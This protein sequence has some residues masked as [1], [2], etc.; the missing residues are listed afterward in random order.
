MKRHIRI[1]LAAPTLALIMQVLQYPAAA[2]EVGRNLELST[3]P[4]IGA[5]TAAC[6]MS[7][8]RWGPSLEGLSGP[9]KPGWV[10]SDGFLSVP[11]NANQSLWLLGDTL[12]G[13][14]SGTRFTSGRFKRNA[15]LV[16][17]RRRSSCWSSLLGSDDRGLFPHGNDARKS[18]I[19]PGTPAINPTGVIAIPMAQ[20][21]ATGGGNSGGFNFEHASSELRTFSWSR[22]SLKELGS[23]PFNF[24]RV[25]PPTSVAT[26]INWTNTLNDGAWVYLFGSSRRAGTMGFD[27]FIARVRS[28]DYFARRGATPSPEFLAQGGWSRTARYSDL[29]RIA[30]ADGDAAFSAVRT[31]SGLH[32]LTKQN[33]ILGNTVLDYHVAGD[34]TGRWQRT[35]VAKVPQRAKMFSYGLAIHP[36]LGI[37]G[38][39]HFVTLNFN[40]T[41]P[42]VGVDQFRPA[43]FRLRLP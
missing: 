33:S 16:L 13:T 17:D 19:W 25:Q 32:V 23:R 42:G 22:G 40:T 10:A 6:Q 11:L 4:G 3:A 30:D 26:H 15:A 43:L 29:R 1:I 27:L 5:T 21:R 12:Y 14:R 18:W 28:G 39:A 41:S 7:E 34:P 38:G 31:S 35:T 36:E 8:R 20:M 9:S 2:D 37:A 24:P